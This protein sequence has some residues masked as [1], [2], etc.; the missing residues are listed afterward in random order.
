MDHLLERAY[1]ALAANGSL[2]L[3]GHNAL[4]LR[5]FNNQPD[6]YG[7]EGVVAL[8]GRF[9]AGRP[10]LL[11]SS[12]VTASLARCG[13]DRLEH[14]AVMGSIKDP[15][16]VVSL[17]GS[18]LGAKQLNLETLVRRSLRDEDVNRLARFSESRVMQ[19][20]VQGGE[21][22][23]WSDG[24][25]FLAHKSSEAQLHVE[26]WLASYFGRD[27]EQPT[28]RE[29]R[30]CLASPDGKDIEVTTAPFSGYEGGEAEP[31]INGSVHRD[32]LDDLLQVPGWTFEQVLHWS[33]VWLRCLLSSLDSNDSLKPEG[34]FAANYQGQYELWVPEW[35]LGATPQRWIKTAEGDFKCLHKRCDVSATLPMAA[36]LFAGLTSTFSTIHSVAAPA[37]DAWLEPKTLTD[38]LIERLGFALDPSDIEVVSDEWQRVGQASLPT[39][40]YFQPREIISEQTDI[41]KLY[42]ATEDEG[43]SERKTSTDTL[44]L[45]GSVQTLNF[46]I[47]LREQKVK[48][49][50]FDVANRPG[51]FEIEDMSVLDAGGE[52]LW[53]WQ[54]SRDELSSIL[55]ATLVTDA[56]AQRSCM[57]SRTNDPQFVLSLP[58][59]VLDSIVGGVLQVKL[60]VWP[61]RL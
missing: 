41:A 50:R 52:V 59:M 45:D 51:C 26:G 57:L 32:S 21:L 46:P 48:A 61:Q 37:V 6:T 34:E 53:C 9:G 1:S 49:L 47:A 44:V 40:G 11:S 23:R 22:Q 39:E 29:L 19:A 58:R 4:A 14:C 42:W 13:F 33:D 20:V 16:L 12:R 25:L 28:S 8:E 60:S 17:Q 5:H 43:F 3:A 27:P 55:G 15:R 38:E 30:F 56:A 36:V 10:Q 18:V 31:Y 54:H 7:R 24:Y 35:L 2:M